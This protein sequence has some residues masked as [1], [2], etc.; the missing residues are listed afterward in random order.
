MSRGRAGRCRVRAHSSL[1]RVRKLKVLRPT[2]LDASRHRGLSKS[3][4]P[5]SLARPRASRKSAS[6]LASRARCLLGLLRIA[7]GGLTLSGLLPYGRTPIHRYRAQTV[8][9]TSDHAG[10]RRQWGLRDARLARRDGAAWTAGEGKPRRIS[11]A[12]SPATAPRPASED[13]VQT[14]LGTEAGWVGL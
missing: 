13:A 8:P 11:D 9:S 10:C 3:G 12:P 4:L 2:G 7:P 5:P 14:P 1:R 6:P